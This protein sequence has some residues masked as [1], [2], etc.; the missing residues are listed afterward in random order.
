MAGTMPK[1]SSTI[2]RATSREIVFLMRILLL[3]V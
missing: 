2:T 3:V 1:V